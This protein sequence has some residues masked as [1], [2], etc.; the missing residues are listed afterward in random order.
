MCNLLNGIYYYF[1]FN[2]FSYLLNYIDPPQPPPPP[3]PSHLRPSPAHPVLGSA[4]YLEFC[5]LFFLFIFWSEQSSSRTKSACLGSL[6]WTYGVFLTSTKNTISG[7]F[8]VQYMQYMSVECKLNWDHMTILMIVALQTALMILWC[9]HVREGI[10]CRF[11]C[12]WRR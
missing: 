5:G 11:G 9:F 12:W 4:K 7:I 2:G 8:V 1:S 3:P 10:L 6:L